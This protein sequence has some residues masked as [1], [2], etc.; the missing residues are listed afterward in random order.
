MFFHRISCLGQKSEPWSTF[1]LISAIQLWLTEQSRTQRVTYIAVLQTVYVCLEWMTLALSSQ[2][3]EQCR[4]L[5]Q[6]LNW[7]LHLPFY[8]NPVSS[9]N[10]FCRVINGGDGIIEVVVSQWGF[11]WMLCPVRV[12]LVQLCCWLC[13]SW[14]S[15]FMLII[16]PYSVR[17]VMET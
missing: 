16:A 9:V 12:F 17:R 2:S 1:P 3:G 6:S 14:T 5:L 10:D 4:V 8:Y 11:L 13:I 15:E 7:S